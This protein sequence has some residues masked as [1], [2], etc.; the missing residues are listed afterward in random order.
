MSLPSPLPEGWYASNERHAAR[1][2]N[3]LQLE[4]PPGHVL[5]GK[6]VEIVAHREGT[7][8]VLCRHKQEPGRFTVI[9]L[10]W[11]MKEEVNPEHPWVEDDGDYESFLRYEASFLNR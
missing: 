10:S 6:P 7:D 1:L 11:A 5:Y 3:E 4:L 9:H 2:Y 8:D